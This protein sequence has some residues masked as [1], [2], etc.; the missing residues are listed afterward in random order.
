MQCSVII[1][2]YNTPPEKLQTALE[3][4]LVQ[5]LKQCEVIVVDDNDSKAESKKIRLLVK[6]L[7]KNKDLPLRKNIKIV[8]KGKNCGL[9]EARRLGV[10]NSS[11]EYITF[12]DS[13]D[14][15]LDKDALKI[16]YEAAIEKEGGYDI[17]QCKAK[18]VREGSYLLEENTDAY[19]LIE[20]P[21][22][23][24]F[25]TDDPFLFAEEYLTTK[26][27]PL[28]LW[29][30][31]FKREV[32]L[33][34][35]DEMPG[36][37]CFMAEDTLFSY[38]VSKHCKSYIGIDYVFYQYNLGKGISTS[39]QAIDSLERWKKFC[40]CASV[41]TAIMYDLKTNGAPEKLVLHFNKI[42]THFAVRNY[43]LLERVSSEIKD[44]AFEILEEMWGTEIVNAV[45]N[46]CN[47]K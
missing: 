22:L 31:L 37:D 8:G 32:F 45:V 34:A 6:S 40:T 11:G 23:G 14:S 12:L 18:G 35:I 25:C 17:V 33:S 2:V 3:S 9:V 15:F 29:A 26:K 44:E 10:L 28:Y 7:Q 30:K 43:K 38:F 16:M 13:D 4:C 42:L 46:H 24:S 47:S 20:S 19:K 36:M 1:P 21:V 27:Y 41:F 39:A 5:T